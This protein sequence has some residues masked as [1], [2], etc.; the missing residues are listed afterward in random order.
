MLSVKILQNSIYFLGAPILNG[1]IEHPMTQAL[2][3]YQLPIKPRI[4]QYGRRVKDEFQL[5][6]R[7]DYRINPMISNDYVDFYLLGELNYQG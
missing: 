7:H 3:Y 6:L 5:D 2:N 4:R 1:M